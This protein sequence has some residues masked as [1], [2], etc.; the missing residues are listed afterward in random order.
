MAHV[1]FPLLRLKLF[2]IRT[3]RASVSGSFFTRLGIGRIPFLF[4]LLY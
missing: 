4:P 1:E 2:C 3:F